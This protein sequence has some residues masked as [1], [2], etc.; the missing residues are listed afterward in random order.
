MKIK[1]QRSLMVS[2]IPWFQIIHG[3]E[4]LIL[5]NITQNTSA[6]NKTKTKK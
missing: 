2:T 4:K 1:E 3:I 5:A 6:K